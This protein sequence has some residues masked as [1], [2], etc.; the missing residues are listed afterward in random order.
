MPV[1]AWRPSHAPIQATDTSPRQP[2]PH[3]TQAP[4]PASHGTNASLHTHT[5]THMRAC[6]RRHVRNG[7][8]MYMAGV[9]IQG[10]CVYGHAHTH[11]S[12]RAWVQKV[13][14][15]ARKRARTQMLVPVHREC[16]CTRAH[17]QKCAIRKCVRRKCACMHART[18]KCSC[19]RA[20][21]GREEAGGRRGKG[22][23]KG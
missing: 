1:H 3:P 7:G 18:H 12:A 15:R 13:C 14:A 5:Y 8:N 10:T 17:A 11:T 20:E 16:V 23:G 9:C 22:R 21:R 19:V 4:K 2:S 6:I